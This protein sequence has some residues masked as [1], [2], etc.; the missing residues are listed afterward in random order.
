MASQLASTTIQ[1]RQS[2]TST[3]RSLVGYEVTGALIASVPDQ[4]RRDIIP[5]G[6][7][8][9]S[10]DDA[11]RKAQS[12]IAERAA[13]YEA[14]VQ[15]RARGVPVSS[16]NTE[17]WAAHVST[18]AALRHALGEFM[19]R[20][21]LR[22]AVRVL[23]RRNGIASHE[24]RLVRVG[25]E[26]PFVWDVEAASGL[27]MLGLEILRLRP[28][29]EAVALLFGLLGPAP[30]SQGGVVVGMG[31]AREPTRAIMGAG[32][33]MSLV[34]RAIKHDASR[35][36][37]GTTNRLVRSE[38]EWFVSLSQSRSAGAQLRS[39]LADQL[40]IRKP[41]EGLFER[42]L[43]PFVPT[44]VDL[45]HLQPAWAQRL[46]RYIIAVGRRGDPRICA[47]RTL[48]G[49]TVVPEADTYGICPPRTASSGHEGR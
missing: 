14:M 30:S 13:W 19:E 26:P 34:M 32:F 47:L 27:E 4:H 28:A 5:F 25:I 12:E 7:W 40:P 49:A 36:L 44:A 17:G 42:P 3:T 15:L 35:Q 33:E 1:W 21:L 23:R 24:L 48:P 18:R 11:R 29:N 10:V 38:L 45:T 22:C 20:R 2:M 31:V 16:F 9:L 43:T 46:N 8:G 41:S 6:S 39:C 37:G